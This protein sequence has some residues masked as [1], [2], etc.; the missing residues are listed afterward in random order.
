[1]SEGRPSERRMYSDANCAWEALRS[2]CGVRPEQVV[3]YGQSIG[4]VPTV[5]LAARVPCA[6]VVLHSPL[7]SGIRV[8][9]SGTRRTWCCDSFA[10]YA[11]CCS[12]TIY[13]IY[14][15]T[16]T[17]APTTSSYTWRL[18]NCTRD[19][20]EFG[21]KPLRPPGSLLG[22][23]SKAQRRD[24]RSCLFLC[25]WDAA[26]NASP[27][28]SIS[29]LGSARLILRCISV[30]SFLFRWATK[31]PYSLVTLCSAR[32][33]CRRCSAASRLPHPLSAIR[34]SS[35]HSARH[36]CGAIKS[37]RLLL[38]VGAEHSTAEHTSVQLRLATQE[39]NLLYCTVQ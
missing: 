12:C 39:Y 11:D 29:T 6:G 22:S 34:Y 28:P 14:S 36:Y 9:C 15:A 35:E 7:T 30:F 32:R 4:T 13:D 1:M 27:T 31:I 23:N 37:I 25:Y 18:E 20:G 19:F 26:W 2:R 17:P 38:A 33:R 16:T 10:R 21:L 8:A 3:L 5:D 24:M